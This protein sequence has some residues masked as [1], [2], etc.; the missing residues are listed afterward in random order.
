MFGPEWRIHDDC[1]ELVGITFS[2]QQAHVTLDKIH[3]GNLKFLGV[4]P[5]YLQGVDVNV[6]SD[7][8]A[9]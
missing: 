3:V 1:V 8:K 4:S 2:F 7:T 5:E 9:D 6:E